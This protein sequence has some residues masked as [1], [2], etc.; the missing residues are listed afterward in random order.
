M[1]AIAIGAM[2]AASQRITFRKILNGINIRLLPKQNS[3]ARESPI[4]TNSNYVEYGVIVGLR[5]RRG[6][7]WEGRQH[8]FIQ[9]R[10]LPP[11]SEA[12]P[13][14]GACITIA[15]AFLIHPY[16]SDCAVWVLFA[17]PDLASRSSS[18]H[19]HLSNQAHR[20]RSQAAP[21]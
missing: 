21:A 15:S 5:V 12:L 18:R 9:I 13:G 20:H 10:T 2:S 8:P 1:L 14:K 4:A 3:A 17:G 19:D 7:G 11:R 6:V 16:T